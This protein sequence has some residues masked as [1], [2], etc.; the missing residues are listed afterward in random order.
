MFKHAIVRTPCPEMIDGITSASLGKPDYNLALKQHAAYVA[1]LK[2]LG[3]KVTVLD[4]DSRFPDSTFVEDVALCTRELA[5]IT[6]PGADSRKGEQLEMVKVLESFY[7]RIEQIKSPGTLEAGDV[8]MAG[9]HFFIGISERTNTE[10]ARQ[11]IHI[12]DSHGMSGEMV[13]LK[14]ILHLK[15]GVSYLEEEVV[16]VGK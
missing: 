11:L 10:G 1:A 6:A 16:L 14:D 9:S 7:D 8:M 4:M 12:L 15:T 13:E 2:K 3:L 5:I